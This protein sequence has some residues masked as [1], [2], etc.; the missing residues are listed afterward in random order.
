[1]FL[2]PQ[3]L[4]AFPFIICEFKETSITTQDQLETIQLVLFIN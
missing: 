2:N 1:M 3:D 4:D